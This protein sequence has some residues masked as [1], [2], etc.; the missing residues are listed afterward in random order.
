MENNQSIF[1]NIIYK[2]CYYIYKKCFI[3]T[4]DEE[5]IVT[6][7]FKQSVDD[8]FIEKISNKI[9]NI[10][11]IENPEIT[12]QI[13]K[14]HFQE[15]LEGNNL[16][17]KYKFPS[18]NINLTREKILRLIYDKLNLDKLEARLFMYSNCSSFY[19]Y[20]KS[21]KIINCILLSILIS[22]IYYLVY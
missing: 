11:K 13:V 6:I 16:D 19:C 2:D 8:D 3:I 21:N 15:E 4:I 14:K 1:R 5:G 17:G 12:R 20:I 9:N 7:N 22:F 10:I 18:K